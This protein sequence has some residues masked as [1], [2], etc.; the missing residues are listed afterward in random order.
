[1]TLRLQELGPNILINAICRAYK[2]SKWQTRLSQVG[3][4]V[5]RGIASKGLVHPLMWQI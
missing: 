5:N 1:M 4:T 3:K 2:N